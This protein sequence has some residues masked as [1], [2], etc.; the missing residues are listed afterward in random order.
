MPASVTIGLLK[1]KI[2][3]LGEKTDDRYVVDG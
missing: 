3:E 1:A 2:K